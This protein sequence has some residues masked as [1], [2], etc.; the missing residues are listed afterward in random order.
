MHGYLI[1]VAKSANIEVEPNEKITAIF[2][3]VRE[4]HPK[5]NY[6]GP[7]ATEIGLVLK[8]GA[9]IID[10]I[11]TVRNNAS[12]AHPNEEV[13]PEAEAMFL[14]NM[15]RSMLHYIEMKLKS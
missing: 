6:I 1:A 2:K 13:V 12:V 14:I 11:N 9:T 5:L 7:R 8:A 3:R 10:S 15:I 4:G